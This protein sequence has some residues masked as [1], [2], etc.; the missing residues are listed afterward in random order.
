MKR[1][2][3]TAQVL[4]MLAAAEPVVLNGTD[5]P[6]GTVLR[7]TAEAYERLDD[8]E[9]QQGQALQALEIV[10]DLLI[11]IVQGLDSQLSTNGDKESL[12][13]SALLRQA[14]ACAAAAVADHPNEAEW[15]R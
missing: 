11:R 14:L 8:A 1:F 10:R 9:Q 5:D 6:L 12:V 4:R 3:T 7:T 2:A 13:I 15:A